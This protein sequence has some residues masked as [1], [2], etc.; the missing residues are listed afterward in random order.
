MIMKIAFKR[1]LIEPIPVLRG[2]T[3]SWGN[4]NRK[5]GTSQISVRW[6]K[7]AQAHRGSKVLSEQVRSN[8]RAEKNQEQQQL[9]KQ[10]PKCPSVDKWTAK[11]W[12]TFNGLVRSLNKRKPYHWDSMDGLRR[13]C[14]AWNKSDKDQWAPYDFTHTWNLKSER[15]EQ[16][17]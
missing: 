1:I 14:A 13:Y 7:G 17:K 15:N 9:R 12:Y 8:C 4:K 6:G 11:L 3:G 16:A 10:P 2:N 5:G